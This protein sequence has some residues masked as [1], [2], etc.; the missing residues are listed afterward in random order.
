MSKP[1]NKEGS[2]KK[3]LKRKVQNR[4]NCL[5]ASYNHNSQNNCMSLPSALH[6]NSLQPIAV[7]QSSACD[8]NCISNDGINSEILL[9]TQDTLQLCQPIEPLNYDSS[10]DISTRISDFSLELA[11]W[12]VQENVPLSTLGKLLILLKGDYPGTQLKS[13]PKDPRSLLRTPTVT[14]LRQLG[15]NGCYYYFGI[16]ES[17]MNLCNKS[18]KLSSTDMFS[19]AV[20]IDGVPLFKSSNESFWPILCMVK[21]IKVLDKKVFCVG[22]YKGVGKPEANEF[23]TD[24]VNECIHLVNNGLLINSQKY[25]FRVSMLI[26]DVPAKA[27]VLYIKSHSAFF[28]CTKCC[29]EGDL[30]KNVLCFLN[31]NF[32]QR[33]DFSFRNR[34]QSEHHTGKSLIENIPD[35]NMINNVPIDYMHCILLGVVKRLLCNKRYGWVYGKPPHKLRAS[36]INSISNE[37]LKLKKFIPREFARKP[38][39]LIE[40][41]RYKAAEFRLLLLYTGLIVFRKVLPSKIYNNFVCLSIATLILVSKEFS[42]NNIFVDYAND[43]YKHFILNSIQIYG[44]DFISH[45]VHNLLHLSECVKLFGCLDSFSA[46]P[47]ENFMPQLIKKV[48]KVAMPLQQVVRRTIEQRQLGP[49]ELNPSNSNRTKFLI[50]H[51]SGPLLQNCNSPQY[52]AM[53]TNEY[54]LNVSKVCDRFVELKDGNIVEIKNFATYQAS[55]VI[56][57]LIYKKSES[58]LKKP[59]NSSHFGI[60]F[61]SKID[62]VQYSF[63]VTS[64]S[65]K[66]MVLPYKNKLVS[67]PLLHL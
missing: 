36:D 13:L 9:N 54:F 11:K 35:F 37:L 31:T 22:L 24:F 48:R 15:T 3:Y 39:S 44:P 58:F 23:L 56:I 12:A 1:F 63:P 45:N 60:N 20:N 43:L 50:K 18:V 38:R 33:T 29:L 55:V 27:Y 26:C 21:S 52:K 4:V 53:Q 5:L 61:I 41:K 57:G 34:S 17:L 67:F 49:L 47:F 25:K 8:L 16:H 65:K 66:V 10:D 14:D 46:F 32:Q 59:C 7:S 42:A 30:H 64:I 6:V 2:G 51:Y 40:C 62:N 19:I 28:S